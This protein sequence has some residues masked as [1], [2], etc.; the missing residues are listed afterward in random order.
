MHRVS[1]RGQQET[2]SDKSTVSKGKKGSVYCQGDCLSVSENSFS[3]T[4]N[5]LKCHYFMVRV[6]KTDI[7]TLPIGPSLFTIN[8]SRRASF[9]VSTL[10]N[11]TK[12]FSS[13]CS[14]NFL[15]L[16]LSAV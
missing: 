6:T 16:F 15:D 12:K 4:D 2:K 9:L 8:K 1:C 11:Y 3:L 7:T 10:S 5:K 13:T 14:R